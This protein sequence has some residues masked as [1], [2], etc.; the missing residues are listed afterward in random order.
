MT[1]EIIRNLLNDIIIYI[2]TNQKK[3]KNVDY[4]AYELIASLCLNNPTIET[5]EQCLDV[6]Y[7]SV[8]EKIKGCSQETFQNYKKDIECRSVRSIQKYIQCFKQGIQTNPVFTQEITA[9]YLEGKTITTPKIIQLNEHV[10]NK[11]AKA[12][13]YIEFSTNE[14]IGV[15]IKQSKNCT[16][17]NYSV[18]KII[19][20]CC[21]NPDEAEQLCKIRK[22]LLKDAGF[23][24]HQKEQRKQVNQLFY[25]KE[26]NIYWNQVKQYISTY[27]ES[28]KKQLVEY[29]YPVE[30]PY[31][32]YEFDGKKL[33]ELKINDSEIVF[34][35]H[36]EYYY[37][38]KKVLR[39]AAK[40]F[41]QLKVNNQTYRVEIR[42]KGNIHDASPQFQLHLDDN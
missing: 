31:V 42:W 25:P 40:L 22:Q 18:E 34:H 15:S 14:I 21:T 19:K 1:E 16:K 10:N 4:N 24:N 20:Q 23:E 29:L 35:E 32:L 27:N 39:N 13:I 8:C 17:S 26:E 2:E 41:Y 11:C 9:I 12:D 30:L 3:R 5:K 38:K 36:D 33:K 37:T 7:E 6:S 28:I